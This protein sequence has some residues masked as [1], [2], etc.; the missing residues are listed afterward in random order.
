MNDRDE[1]LAG[2]FHVM[3]DFEFV[4]VFLTRRTVGTITA[5]EAP[6]I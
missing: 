2:N 6:S 4:D 3:I 5:D 1:E